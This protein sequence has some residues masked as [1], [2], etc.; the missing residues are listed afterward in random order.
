M[1]EKDN[2]PPPS[3]PVVKSSAKPAPKE[4]PKEIVKTEAAEFTTA[5]PEVPTDT[6]SLGALHEEAIRA[7]GVP[8]CAVCDKQIRVG[9]NNEPICQDNDRADCPGLKQ[10]RANAAKAHA[11]RAQAK[12]DV[13]SDRLDRKK[14]ELDIA[15]KAIP[16]LEDGVKAA[17]SNLD[18]AKAELAAAQKELAKLN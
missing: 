18:E 5:A 11:E 9:L 13:Y 15:K 12:V 17:A 1:S 7:A 6:R 3:E 14:E 2:I 10:K 4:P 8:F 16:T